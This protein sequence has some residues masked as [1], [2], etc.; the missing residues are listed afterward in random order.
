MVEGTIA[1]QCEQCYDGV[2]AGGGCCRTS[3]TRYLAYP[4]ERERRRKKM[5][6]W[7]RGG[8]RKERGQEKERS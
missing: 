7:D 4:G 3:E 1:V 6:G 8:V 5:M 2:G